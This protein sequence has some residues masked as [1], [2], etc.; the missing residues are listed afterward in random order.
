MVDGRYKFDH[1]ELEPRN[2]GSKR[3]LPR[4]CDAYQQPLGP[5]FKSIVEYSINLTAFYDDFTVA[6]EWAT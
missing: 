4:D 1:P 6:W 3:Q 5:A 2:K